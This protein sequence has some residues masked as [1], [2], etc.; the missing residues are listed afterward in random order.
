MKRLTFIGA[1]YLVL[2][3]LTPEILSKTWQVQ[4]PFVGTSLL[5][6]VV[7][8]LDFITQVQSYLMSQKYENMLQKGK[9]SGKKLHLIR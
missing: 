8:I 2:V 5:I 3:V 6:I 7:V 4:L 1:L 9:K